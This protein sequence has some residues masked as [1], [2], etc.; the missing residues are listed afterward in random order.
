[1][2]ASEISPGLGTVPPPESPA[3]EMVWCGERNGLAFTSETP[4]G[5]FPEMEYIFVVSSDSS[6]VISGRI[7]GILFA[8]ILFPEPGGPIIIMLCPPAAATS[9][10]LL[11]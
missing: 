8:S 11:G 2:W 1:M 6:K 7:D 10:A 4:L 9:N 5:S 3:G